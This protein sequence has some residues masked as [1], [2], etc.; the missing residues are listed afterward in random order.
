MLTQKQK[1]DLRDWEWRWVAGFQ[2]LAMFMV[3]LVWYSAWLGEQALF[4][5]Q[6]F[7]FFVFVAILG[8]YAWSRHSF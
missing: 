7:L 8:V 5:L 3:G 4:S 6:F 2:A 1:R